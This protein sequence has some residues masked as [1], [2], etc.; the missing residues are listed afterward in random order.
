[1]C[2]YAKYVIFPMCDKE[3][4]SFHAFCSIVFSLKMTTSY[5]PALALVLAV[6]GEEAAEEVAAAAG[7]VHQGALLTQAEA[8]RHSQHQGDSLDQQRPL[9]QVAPDDEA[10]EDGLD[11]SETHTHTHTSR[12]PSGQ[13]CCSLLV[14]LACAAQHY[15]GDS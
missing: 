10:A 4:H 7:H 12:D 2:K 6:L 15:L 5:L 14:R 8:R 1:M 11:L 13:F 9:T 3:R